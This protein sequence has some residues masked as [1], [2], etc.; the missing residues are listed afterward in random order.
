MPLMDILYNH[1][2]LDSISYQ[3]CE[4]SARK[5]TPSHNTG[6]RSVP[7]HVIICC[8][9]DEYICELYSGKTY[10]IHKGE[11]VFVPADMKHRMIVK[12]EIEMSFVHIHYT[13]LGTL[14]ILSLFT[15]PHV[16]NVEK[17]T[18]I[19]ECIELI[20]IHYF[21]DNEL[22]PINTM[23]EQRNAAF[24]LLQV[25]IAASSMNENAPRLL[26]DILKIYPV[27]SYMQ[28]NVATISCRK[29]LS[30]VINISETRFHYIFKDI[31]GYSPISYLK[32]IRLKKS[33]MLLLTTDMSVDAISRQVGYADVFNFS[34]QFKKQLGTSPSEY[35]KYHR[36]NI[37]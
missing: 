5:V 8:F 33:Q 3:F 17:G 24:R 15:V 37:V 4:G 2:L 14:D 7:F 31:T 11:A 18:I 12:K 32:I 13:I 28:K 27:L 25:I 21:N 26:S 35:R 29:E 6:W 20:N 1:F 9:G 30:D 10:T 34:K 22:F 16:F 23:L 36:F 19:A